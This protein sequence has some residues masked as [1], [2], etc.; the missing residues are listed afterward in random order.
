[1]KLKN[2]IAIITGAARGIGLACAERF[3]TE[4]AH[5]IIVDVLDEIGKVEAKR[6]GATY[7]HC[8]VS[9][10]SDVNAVVAAVVK[11]HGAVDILLNNAA[12]SISGDFLEISESDYDKVLDINLKG[13]FLMLQACAREMV[14][15]AAGSI[16]N[17]SSVNDTLA[18]PSIVSY[19]VAKGGIS[20]LTRATSISLAPHGIR[21]NAIGPGSI[22]TDMLKSVVNDKAAMARVMSRTPM[23]RVG[24]P[25][26][27]ASIAVF[28]A[29]DDSSYVTGQ[30]I[31][32][33]GGRMPLNYTVPV[34]E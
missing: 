30:T 11:Q 1:M 20:Q 32:A 25:S 17:M 3:V 33:D 4:G 27:I 22:M 13:S 16:I 12:I 5:V 21:V 31:Y 10:S 34:K 8:D 19:C 15:Q 28:L 2:R 26:E 24:N 29:S 7:M 23:G 6:L 18:I 14:K 9:K